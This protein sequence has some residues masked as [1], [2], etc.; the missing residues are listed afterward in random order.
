MKKAHLLYVLLF[1]TNTV[2]SQ[3]IQFDLKSGSFKIPLNTFYLDSDQ[4]LNYRYMCFETLPTNE[5]R[6]SLEELGVDFL[7]YIPKNIYIV[8]FQDRLSK[9]VLES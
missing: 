9:S 4:D 8:S 3:E 6:E 7:E 1:F 2:L 5:E